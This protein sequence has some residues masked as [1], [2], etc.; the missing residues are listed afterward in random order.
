MVESVDENL[1]F[2]DLIAI[3][4]IIKDFLNENQV[5]LYYYCDSSASDIFIRERKDIMLPQEFR[6]NL[7]NTLFDFL[8]ITHF[9]KDEI[10]ID[11]HGANAH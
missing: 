10:I 6:H 9:V 4:R 1:E 2:R 11:D 7:F 3:V 5:V 8:R